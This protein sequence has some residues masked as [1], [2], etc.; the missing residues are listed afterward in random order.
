MMLREKFDWPIVSLD[1]PSQGS[2]ED[3]R[4]AGADFQPNRDNPNKPCVKV[5]LEGGQSAAVLSGA[6][7]EL[8]RLARLL[9]E[10]AAGK[11]LEEAGDLPWTKR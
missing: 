5:F 9:R 8:K 7:W 3:S 1:P 11:T 10:R 2:E 6:R 4:I